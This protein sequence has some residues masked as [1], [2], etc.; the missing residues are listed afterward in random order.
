VA[1]R[2]HGHLPLVPDDDGLAADNAAGPPS[3]AARPFA[4]LRRIPHPWPMRAGRLAP[5]A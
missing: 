5:P 4:S 3:R 1:A 2:A